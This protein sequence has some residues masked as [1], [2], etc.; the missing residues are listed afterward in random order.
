MADYSKLAIL[1]INDYLWQKLQDA[2]LLDKNRYFADGFIDYLV[3]IIPAQQVP[4][5]N[6]LLPGET[7][8]VYDYEVKSS[9]EHWWITDEVAY[10][11]IFSTDYDEINKIMNFLQDNFRRY[12][13]MAKDINDDVQPNSQFVYHYFYIDKIESAQPFRTEGGYM[14]G[15][16]DICYSYTRKL[17]QNGRFQ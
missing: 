15:V 4:E 1:E 16:A 6:N 14:M 3:P 13:S 2:N 8:I 10:Y 12:D 9:P 5:F 17:D 7:Y 11:S